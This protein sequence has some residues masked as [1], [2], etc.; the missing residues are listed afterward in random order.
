MTSLRFIFIFQKRQRQSFDY[1]EKMTSDFLHILSILY[2]RENNCKTAWKTAFYY[3]IKRL[4]SEQ[5]F[6]KKKVE[7]KLEERWDDGGF[8]SS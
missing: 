7:Y 4:N 1:I 6:F 3:V 5:F 2:D 8:L